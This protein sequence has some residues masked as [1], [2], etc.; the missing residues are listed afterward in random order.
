MSWWVKGCYGGLKGPGCMKGWV[1]GCQSG[2]RG[3]PMAI[4]VGQ[5]VL[6]WGKGVRVA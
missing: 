2:L 1:K 4:R 6:W 3:V 5:G